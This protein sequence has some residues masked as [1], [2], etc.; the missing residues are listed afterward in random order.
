M[1]IKAFEVVAAFDEGER[2]QGL[3]STKALAN[4]AKERYASGYSQAVR[5][6]T[7]TVHESLAEWKKIDKPD[8]RRAAIAKLSEEEI[9]MCGL[10]E[11]RDILAED[12]RLK[13]ES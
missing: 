9:V 7:V 12:A 4:A 11:I 1:E 8:E 3:F 13:A 5:P 10:A 6:V 2:R